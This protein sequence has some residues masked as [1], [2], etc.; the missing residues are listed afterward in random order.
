MEFEIAPALVAGFVGTVVMTMGMQMGKSMGMTEMD[1]ALITGGMVTSD[2]RKARRIGMFIHLV[3]MGT[4]VFGIAYALLFQALDSASWTA[5]LGIGLAHGAVVGIIAMPMMGGIHPRMR[6]AAEGFQMESPGPFGINYG[7]GTPMGL[8]M[9][10][11]LYGVVLALV[12]D[13]LI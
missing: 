7:K 5:G 3:M 6:A 2:E 9:G 13:A 11:A 4:V 10:H 8:L 12:Y 1:I